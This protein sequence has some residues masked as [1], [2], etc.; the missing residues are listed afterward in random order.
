[1]TTFADQRFIYAPPPPPTRPMRS[2]PFKMPAW[3]DSVES[4][5]YCPVSPVRNDNDVP[6]PPN[7]SASL[8]GEVCQEIVDGQHVLAYFKPKQ[9][10][11]LLQ[12][13]SDNVLPTSIPKTTQTK[14]TLTFP[15]AHPVCLDTQS[16]AHIAD[17]N[18]LVCE[19]TDGVRM[20]MCVCVW[21]RVKL[22]VL[23][24]RKMHI[25]HV[26]IRSVPKV[27]YAGSVFDGELAWDL[28]NHRYTY[29]IYDTLRIGK[30]DVSKCQMLSERIMKARQAWSAY[31]YNSHT[32]DVCVEI[33]DMVSVSDAAACAAFLLAF[34]TAY[35]KKQLK[36]E[37]YAYPRLLRYKIDG[38]VFSP[39]DA[40]LQSGRQWNLRKWKPTADMTV[41]LVVDAKRKLCFYDAQTKNHVPVGVG[42]SAK[43][44]PG[45]IVECRPK[46]SQG[47]VS[48]QPVKLR[49]D[50][51]RAN[52]RVTYEG[53]I[54]V[55]KEGLT[56]THVMSRLISN[57]PGSTNPKK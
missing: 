1:M 27:L 57:E 34:S 28:V 42:C 29:L 18:Y 30:D 19:K 44:K 49:T 15:G 13:I 33:K 36:S 20:F 25:K 11:D 56:L 37:V 3:S 9:Q 26:H 5:I 41:D 6:A 16:L 12:Y 38:L 14:Q 46:I 23:I 31:H 32:D 51:Q 21:N 7:K 43:Y 47:D 24:D 48:W 17:G 53:T 45:D 39:E 50:K 2:P 4:P 40:P 22:C 54:T 8:E 35:E 52:D 10:D 55:I